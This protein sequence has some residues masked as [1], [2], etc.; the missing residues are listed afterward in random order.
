MAM[1]IAVV[2]LGLYAFRHRFVKA[3]ADM[4]RYLPQ[5]GVTTFYADVAGLRRAGALSLITGSTPTAEPEYQGF[6]RET[7]FDYAKDLDALVG[8][9]DGEQTFFILRG[10]FNLAKLRSYAAHHGGGCQDEICTVPTSRQKQILS[11]TSIQ[12]DVLSLALSTAPFA[13]TALDPP[14]HVVRDPLPTA[15]VW[16]RVSAAVLKNPV[17]LP[18]GLRIFAI[19]LQ[20]AES[21]VLSLGPATTN[22]PGF[23]LGLNAQCQ[24]AAA[25]DTMRN[26]L[27]IETKMLKLELA[28]ERAQPSDADLTGLLTA[29][30]FQVIDKRV[31]G[32]WPV[33]PELMKALQ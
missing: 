9:T 32:M 5:A 20:S 13:V 8:A 33:K 30:S 24:N 3:N 7:Q 1:G 22:S 6:V 19:S 14:G 10:R 21:V 17:Q 29:G 11:F 16:V 26:Q 27:E 15:P 25:A 2:G 31:L 12:P 28:R 18:A 4:L 23:T